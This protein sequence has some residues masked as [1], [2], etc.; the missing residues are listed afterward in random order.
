MQT[1]VDEVKRSLAEQQ[2]SLM[3][4]Q[5]TM[6]GLAVAWVGLHV[7]TVQTGGRPWVWEV[8]TPH[9][10]EASEQLQNDPLVLSVPHDVVIVEMSHSDTTRP[11]LRMQVPV[12]TVPETL[13]IPSSLRKTTPWSVRLE[14]GWTVQALVAAAQRWID[15]EVPGAV[16]LQTPA[17]PVSAPQLYQ[18]HPAINIE[19]AAFDHLLTLDPHDAAVV[20]SVLAHVHDALQPYR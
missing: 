12:H 10:Y 19:S 15:R 3:W 8:V 20:T 5:V 17:A 18:L 14:T 4:Q 11:V 9:Q 1:I 16:R 2:S 13:L 7:P 6:P